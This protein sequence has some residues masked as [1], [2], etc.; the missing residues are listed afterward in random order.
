MHE[1][2]STSVERNCSVGVAEK[3][4]CKGDMSVAHFGRV[5]KVRPVLEFA[6]GFVEIIDAVAYRNRARPVGRSMASMIR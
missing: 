1:N 4:L 3:L 5:R 6:S 2:V